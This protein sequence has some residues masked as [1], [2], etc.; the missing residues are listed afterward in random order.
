MIFPDGSVKEGWF[1]NNVFVRQCA[2][3]DQGGRLLRRASLREIAWD[4]YQDNENDFRV[5][6]KPHSQNLISSCE[7]QHI[8]E[9]QD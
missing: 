6:N 7:I 9:R 8:V 1:E 2:I 4:A 3:T 5:G